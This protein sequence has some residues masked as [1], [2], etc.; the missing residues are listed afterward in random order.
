LFYNSISQFLHYSYGI[1]KNYVNY[2]LH[3]GM[4]FGVPWP[5]SFK[6]ANIPVKKK[7]WVILE[8]QEARVRS[9]WRRIWRCLVYQIFDLKQ[10]SKIPIEKILILISVKCKNDKSVAAFLKYIILSESTLT[11]LYEVL[12]D[13]EYLTFG[14]LLD[15]SLNLAFGCPLLYST[16]HVSSFAIGMRHH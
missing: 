1:F 9:L 12:N 16:S 13:A 7:S 15:D 14:V 11:L 5:S 8:L 2:D 3:F 10:H 6:S 4:L